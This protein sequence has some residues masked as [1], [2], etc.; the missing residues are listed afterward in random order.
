MRVEISISLLCLLLWS[1]NHTPNNRG[2]HI[3]PL[4]WF[5]PPKLCGML[6]PGILEGVHLPQMEKPCRFLLLMCKKTLLN[7]LRWPSF[8]TNWGSLPVHA[9][10]SEKPNR[11]RTLTGGS[12]LSFWTFWP[13]SMS[14]WS[15][16][17]S[18]WNVKYWSKALYLP[19]AAHCWSAAWKI[20]L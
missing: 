1:G 10:N 20:K 13:N 4:W 2:A 18:V 19:L 16:F 15:F 3:L 14:D 8:A 6:H 12:Q 9:F 5:L 17:L 7:D 11:R